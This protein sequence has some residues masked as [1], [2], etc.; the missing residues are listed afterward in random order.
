MQRR[1]ERDGGGRKSGADRDRPPAG[2]L[3]RSFAGP[4]TLDSAQDRIAFRPAHLPVVFPAH[5]RSTRE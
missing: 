4:G 2:T 5:A 1:R 3:P